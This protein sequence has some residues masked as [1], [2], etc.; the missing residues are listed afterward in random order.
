MK[1]AIQTYALSFFKLV[2]DAL[3]LIVRIIKPRFHLIQRTKT[4]FA[5]AAGVVHAAYGNTRGGDG[6][7]AHYP[8]SLS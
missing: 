7:G 3:L 2:D 6:R 4:P 1:C 8:A 5:E